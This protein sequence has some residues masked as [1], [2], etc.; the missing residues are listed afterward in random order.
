[1]NKLSLSFFS[2]GA[3][4]ALGGMIWGNYMGATGDFTLSPAHAHLN[5]VGW[6]SLAIMGTFYAL[7]GKSG[8]LG[9]ANFGLSTSGVVVMIP[10]LARYLLGD[11]GAHVGVAVGGVLALLGMLTFVITVLSGWR[12]APN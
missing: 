9:W 3:L 10:F 4:C 7:S 1:M 2:A 8:R 5:L 6:A 12:A 11:P